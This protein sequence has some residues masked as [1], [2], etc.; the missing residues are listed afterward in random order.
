MV[1][2][3]PGTG[4]YIAAYHGIEPAPLKLTVPEGSVEIEAIGTGT[5]VWDNGKVTIDAIDLEGE[6]IVIGGSLVR[7][8]DRY[9]GSK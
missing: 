5:V 9:D 8:T 3:A 2:C 1:I 7:Y 6:P 4:K